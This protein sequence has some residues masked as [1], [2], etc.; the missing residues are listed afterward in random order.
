MNYDWKIIA[1]VAA[2][3]ALLGWWV[4]RT[5]SGSDVDLD[6]IDGDLATLSQALRADSGIEQE[7]LPAATAQITVPNP[8]QYSRVAPFW[9]PALASGERRER[10]HRMRREPP[11]A[12]GAPE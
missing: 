5:T 10:R 12:K 3:A 8:L 4:M 2:I 11:D 7:I 9:A 1:A 6:G